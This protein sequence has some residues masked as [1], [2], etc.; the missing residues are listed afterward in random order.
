MGGEG[1]EGEK[2][3]TDCVYEPLIMPIKEQVEGG[4]GEKEGRGERGM[5]LMVYEFPTDQ[6]TERHR[7]ETRRKTRGYTV[8][9]PSV[10]LHSPPH[11]PTSHTCTLLPR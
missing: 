9:V 4:E 2:D 10:P 1:G 3:A 11:P 7:H 5:S 6:E 8:Q